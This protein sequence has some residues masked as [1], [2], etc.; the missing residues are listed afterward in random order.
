M[1]CKHRWK[2]I[3]KEVLKS[4]YEQMAVIGDWSN[5]KL[6]TD[7]IM[8]QK[9]YICILECRRCGEVKKLVEKLLQEKGR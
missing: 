7:P 1:K 6:N 3:D 5:I 8:F 9:K 2:I 4:P